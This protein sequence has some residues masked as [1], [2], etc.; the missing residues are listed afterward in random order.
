[1]TKFDVASETSSCFEAIS[2]SAK[3]YDC[4]KCTA[5]EDIATH[6]STCE[7]LA[8]SY[9]INVCCSLY[10]TYKVDQKFRKLFCS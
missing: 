5:Y 4:E 10:S 2:A 9:I 3:D 6:Q 1:M 7:K 8:T